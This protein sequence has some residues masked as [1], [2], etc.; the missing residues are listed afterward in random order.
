MGKIKFEK[1]NILPKKMIIAVWD[2][3]SNS[4]VY[5]IW[6]GPGAIIGVGDRK[7][8]VHAVP[9]KKP[10]ALFL[11]QTAPP[12]TPQL[13]QEPANLRGARVEFQEMGDRLATLLECS[14][15]FPSA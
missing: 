2:S 10:N 4:A 15:N 3:K 9:S 13:A 7:S 1:D 5:T 8:G 6:L 12:S 14:R 11:E